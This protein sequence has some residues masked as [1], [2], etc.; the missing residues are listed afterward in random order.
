M[1]NHDRR[2]GSQRK[3][4]KKTGGVKVEDSPHPAHLLPTGIE[5]VSQPHDIAVVQLT[6]D[7]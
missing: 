6:H 4:G 2:I 3:A 5:K 7:L 1:G